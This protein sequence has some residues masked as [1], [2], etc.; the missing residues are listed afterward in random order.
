METYFV[1]EQII[2][3]VRQFFYHR[4]FHEVIP[5]ILNTALPLEPNLI[6]FET[7]WK[8]RTGDKK[9]YLPLSPERSIKRMLAHGIGNCFAFGKSFRNLEQ[10]GTQH[11]PEFI[12]LEW[13]RKNTNYLDI[14]KEAEHLILF[15]NDYL[16]Q[17][18]EEK[19]ILYHGKKVDIHTEWKTYSLDD[20][21]K[22][23]TQVSLS[24]LIT[25]EELFFSFAKKRGYIVEG[26]TWSEL[27][28]Q[29]YVNEIESELPKEPL[30]LIDFPARV[31]PLC[32]QKKENPLFA[33]RFELFITGVE[34][35]NGNTENTNCEYVRKTFEKE[36]ERTRMPIDEEFL[37]SL[38]KMNGETYAGIG[39][40]VDRLTMLFG[41]ETT[42][43]SI[44]PAGGDYYL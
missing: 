35:A 23:R 34:I 39:L 14:M 6:P 32:K 17:S 28:D 22:T 43:Q 5:Q 24:T 18:T 27:F 21:F 40:G 8:T 1:R 3:A 15:I 13:Y 29:M 30:F 20:L 44:E 2:R 9:L 33:E 38:E 41:N 36:H 16:I 42:I 26:A 37:H 12:M 25:D 11:L 4:K 31:S 7:T 19:N 10:E